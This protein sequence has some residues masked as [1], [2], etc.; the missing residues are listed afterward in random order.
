[1]SGGHFNG[2]GYV[3]YRV[4]QFS[5]ELESEILN[6]ENKDEYNYCP[7]YNEQTLEVLRKQI[8]LIRKAAE[9]MRA[10]DYLYSG[11]HGEDSFIEKIKQIE[12]SK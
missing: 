8:P 10:I 4:D 3:Y 2:N 7:N 5:D 6:N 9:I 1:M 12:E 11:D